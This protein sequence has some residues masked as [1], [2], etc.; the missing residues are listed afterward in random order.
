MLQLHL[1]IWKIVLIFG[2]KRLSYEGMNLQMRKN[3]AG[4]K[5]SRSLYPLVH[6]HVLHTIISIGEGYSSCVFVIPALFLYLYE[7]IAFMEKPLLLICR[8]Y[9]PMFLLKPTSRFWKISMAALNS[10]HDCFPSVSNIVWIW[11]TSGLIVNALS[12]ILLC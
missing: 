1:K 2:C 5:D 3:K 6:L 12:C 7:L 11:S 8:D 4:T 10:P 9:S